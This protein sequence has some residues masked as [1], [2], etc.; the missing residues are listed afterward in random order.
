[1]ENYERRFIMTF[2]NETLPKGRKQKTTSL[3]DRLIERGAVMGDT[4]GLEHAL[5]FAKNKQD[6]FEDPTFKRSRAHNY[7]AKE[8]EAVRNSVGFSEIANFSKH[9]I[10]GK[11]AKNCLLLS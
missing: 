3:Y 11:N 4:F 2:P 1:M 9:L 10:T 8:V 7:I 5:W 6:A